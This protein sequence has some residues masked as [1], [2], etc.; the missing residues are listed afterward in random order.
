MLD[1]LALEDSFDKK[2]IA[3]SGGQIKNEVWLKK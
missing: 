1:A 2:F 3:N